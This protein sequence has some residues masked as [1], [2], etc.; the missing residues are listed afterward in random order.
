MIMGWLTA[1]QLSR[2]ALVSALI[3]LPSGS[4]WAGTYQLVT[5]NG[6]EVCEA[7]KRNFE[8]RHDPVPM[9]CE[10]YYDPDIPG[11]A[12][13]HWISLD[14]KKHFELYKKTQ[15][16]L[17]RNDNSPQ[18]AKLSDKEITE[19]SENL[20]PRAETWHVRLYLA[21]LD[22]DGDGKLLNV[23]MVEQRGCGPNAKPTDETTKSNLFFLRSSLTDI[24]YNRQD[25]MNGWFENATIEIYRGKP[26]IE[27]Y[28][29]DDDWFHL[30]SGNGVLHVFQYERAAQIAREFPQAEARSDGPVKICE[31]Q[32]LHNS[33]ERK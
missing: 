33:T 9:A 21:R 4:A 3:C 23:L 30:L 27:V 11:F 13:V 22:L 29:A 2:G 18:G 32:Y 14:L 15:V 24:D 6:K 31:V 1:L 25:N 10:R 19:V 20:E 17:L 8:P 28:A 5:G 7:Y 12:R 16:Y 26:Y